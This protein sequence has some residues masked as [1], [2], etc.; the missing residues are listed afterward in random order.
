MSSVSREFEIII[1]IID[2]TKIFLAAEYYGFLAFLASPR[3]AENSWKR[4][5][6]NG[7]KIRSINIYFDKLSANEAKS[8]LSSPILFHF[9]AFVT[10]E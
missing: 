4:N 6:V 9:R 10:R 3:F 5:W 7:P 2:P 1:N 8:K